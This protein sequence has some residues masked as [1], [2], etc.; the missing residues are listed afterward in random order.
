MLVH[1]DTLLVQEPLV[2]ERHAGSISFLVVATS[3]D[4]GHCGSIDFV[5]LEVSFLWRLLLYVGRNIYID[6]GVGLITGWNER[7]ILY[8]IYS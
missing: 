7:F 3:G 1:E 2:A 8:D 6:V 5:S 4:S